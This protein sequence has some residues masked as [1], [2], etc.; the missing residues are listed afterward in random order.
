MFI[1]VLINH[2]KKRTKLS[3]YDITLKQYT[4][5]FPSRQ[6]YVYTVHVMVKHYSRYITVTTDK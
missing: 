2:F 1:V 6:D 5:H 4:V 3:R